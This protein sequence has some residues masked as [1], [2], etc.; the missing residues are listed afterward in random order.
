MK[1]TKLV[2]LFNKDKIILGIAISIIALLTSNYVS[3][4]LS[5]TLI[6]LGI[7]ILIN[8]V[9]SLF[10]SYKLY[11][12]SN[13]Y[14]PEKLFKEVNFKKNDKVIFLHASFDP[15]SRDIE[16]LINSNNL[17]IYNLYGNRHENEKSIETSN[18]IFHLIQNK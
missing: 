11:D 17:K 1:I 4:V 8:I 13:L 18:R 10:A 6:G 7:L 5:K 3:L 9:I 14:K 12:K 16:Q 15:I 2:I